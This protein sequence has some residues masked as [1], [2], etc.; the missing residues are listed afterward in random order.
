MRLRILHALPSVNPADGGP[1]E[2]VRQL[3]KVNLAFGHQVEVVCLDAP[4]APW[5]AGIGVRVHALGP[6]Y[7]RYG[8]APGFVP[9]LRQHIHHYDCVIVNGIWQYHCFAV[10]LVLHNSTVPYFVFT[11]GMLDPW[12]KQ[13]PWTL[14]FIN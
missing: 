3:S 6:G 5:L 4:D 14:Y 10:W 7:G 2:G 11:H 1:V 9:W 12:F 8:Y 13:L